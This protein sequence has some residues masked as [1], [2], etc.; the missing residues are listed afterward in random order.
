MLQ[1]VVVYG[2]D[3]ERA[4]ELAG[5][6]PA[7]VHVEADDLGEL[8][9]REHGVL[10]EVDRGVVDSR[11]EGPGRVA[12]IEAYS[13]RP[14]VLGEGRGCENEEQREPQAAAR[15]GRAKRS[16]RAPPMR[17]SPGDDSVGPRVPSVKNA[18]AYGARGCWWSTH[19]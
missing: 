16:A 12:R 8:G 3:E 2:N 10:P 13:E 9:P 14:G 6:S 18:E 15:D 4:A 19:A 7:H 11:H 1:P 17:I 5:D